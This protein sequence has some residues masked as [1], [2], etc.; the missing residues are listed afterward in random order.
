MVG[1]AD[2]ESNLSEEKLLQVDIAEAGKVSV[3]RTTLNRYWVFF[4]LR[5]SVDASSSSSSSLSHS[6]HSSPAPSPRGEAVRC[7]PSLTFVSEVE[8]QMETWLMMNIVC[9]GTWW[10]M[11][12]VVPTAVGPSS[13]L[14]PGPNEGQA[15]TARPAEVL[16]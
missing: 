11:L 7:L 1:V 12:V 6:T 16:R 8:A 9:L 13:C 15:H 5:R 10:T 2:V 4:F 14:V 3:L